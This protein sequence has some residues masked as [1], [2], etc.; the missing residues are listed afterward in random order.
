MR[1]DEH[2]F[3]LDG[4]PVYYRNADA[5]GMP[6]LYLHGIPT[7]SDDWLELLARTGGVA[8]DLIGFGRSGKGGHLDYSVSGLANFVERFLIH[9]GIEE[10]QIVGH[11][12]GAAVALVLYRRRHRRVHRL[13]LINPPP[14][15][16]GIAWP[17][18]VRLWR[19]RGVGELIMGATTKGLLARAL[20]RGSRRADAWSEERID[21]VWRQFDQ[22]TQRAILRLVRSGG[23]DVIGDSGPRSLGQGG[24]TAD[25]PADAGPGSTVGADPPADAGPGSTLTA[26]ARPGAVA[27]VWGEEDPWYPPAL[28]D[29]YAARLPGATVIRFAGAGHWP[30]LDRP[31]VVDRVAALLEG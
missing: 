29:A 9:V 4:S 3:H 6:K 2:T 30:W 5:F 25:A 17:R 27:I 21:T 7:S 16:D 15:L 12:W 28:A 19:S 31:E 13:I 1:V 10:L 23:H 20:R 22:G 14:L 24:G 18:L 26:D 11:D 8:P